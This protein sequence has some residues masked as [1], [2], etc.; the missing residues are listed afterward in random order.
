M[1]HITVNIVADSINH[2]GT[3]LTTFQV[4]VP[5]FLLQEIN[6]HRVFSRSYNSARAIPAKVMRLSATFEPD[7]WLSNKPGMTGG[8][9]LTGIKLFCAKAIWK[10]LIAI[11]KVGHKGLEASGLHKQYTNR[12]LEPVVWVD[13][14]ISS[15]EWDNFL[16]LRTHETAQP[17]IQIL[18]RLIAYQLGA[19]Q[20]NFLCASDWHLPYID[21]ADRSLPIEKQC[22]ISAARCAR[23]SYGFKNKVDVIADLKR[24]NMLFNSHPKHLSPAE[25]V[26]QAPLLSEGNFKSGNFKDWIQYRKT[27]E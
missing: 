9:E 2:T 18:A 7:T 13:G 21:E 17:E 11:V 27:L 23:I 24:A 14:V 3:R 12:W 20:P 8:E 26:A 15:T 10:T 19:N 4:R 5:K 1:S 22:L 16:L 25:H 6:T